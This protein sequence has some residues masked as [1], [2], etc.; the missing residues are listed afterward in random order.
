[1]SSFPLDAE[2]E[3]E[4]LTWD[5]S[6]AIALALRRAHAQV[7]LL[8][9]SLGMIY[10]WTLELP[11]FADDPQLA[12]EGILAAIYQDWFEEVISR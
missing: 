4:P 8:A 5:S 11:A 9:V 7:D 10:Q 2:D 6:Y 3:P 12:N 1:M